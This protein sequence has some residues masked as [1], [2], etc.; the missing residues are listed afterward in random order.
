MLPPNR[1]EG[2]TQCS[3][4]SSRVLYVERE[5]N[6]GI[7]VNEIIKEAVPILFFFPAGRRGYSL[8]NT[9]QEPVDSLSFILLAS[10]EQLCALR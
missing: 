4:H 6:N 10:L 1:L 3:T 8:A 7:K 9:Q 5:K 2:G